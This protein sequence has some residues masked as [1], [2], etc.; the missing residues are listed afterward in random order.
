[1]NRNGKNRNYL[2]ALCQRFRQKMDNC[3]FERAEGES[4]NLFLSRFLHFAP[5]LSAKA[6]MGALVETTV[7]LFNKAIFQIS[8]NRVTFSNCP[9]RDCPPSC[10]RLPPRLPTQGGAAGKKAGG[11]QTSHQ[12]KKD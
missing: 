10:F 1:M 5:V 9:R 8:R 2:A 11:K 7:R 3:H 6:E 12:Q 4:R